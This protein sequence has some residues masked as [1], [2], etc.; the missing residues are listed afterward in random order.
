M[1]AIQNT[2]FEREPFLGEFGFGNFGL[3]IHE[4]YYIEG[5]ILLSRRTH[6]FDVSAF[7]IN[8]FSYPLTV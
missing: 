6:L 4:N 8:T 3:I 5:F 2:Q 7:L 1:I